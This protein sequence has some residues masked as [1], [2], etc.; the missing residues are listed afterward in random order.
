[1][2]MGDLGMGRGGADSQCQAQGRAGPAGHGRERLWAFGL[3]GRGGRLVEYS[4]L[5][6]ARKAL[7][8]R[9][10]FDGLLHLPSD[11][12][13]SPVPGPN[14]KIFTSTF[15]GERERWRQRGRRRVPGATPD[16]Q[17]RLI[18]CFQPDC[19]ASFLFSFYR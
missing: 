15:R 2:L 14:L 11:T 1:M 16:T 9:G 18:S 12:P 4:A 17:H 6:G 7:D 13:Q 5:G 19:E 3:A 8:A 10:S